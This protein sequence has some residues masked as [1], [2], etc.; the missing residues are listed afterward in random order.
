MVLVHLSVD[1]FNTASVPKKSLIQKVQDPP[2]HHFLCRLKA[3]MYICRGVIREV[4][5]EGQKH[6]F[7][8]VGHLELCL[9]KGVSSEHLE[10]T[11]ILAACRKN[12]G[13]ARRVALMWEEKQGALRYRMRAS[14]AV[15]KITSLQHFG[16]LTTLIPLSK[17]SG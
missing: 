17:S 2:P 15:I 3:N 1:L 13:K 9:N 16:E 5:G 14:A 10:L 4:V 6:M 12:G 8:E 7:R 11:V